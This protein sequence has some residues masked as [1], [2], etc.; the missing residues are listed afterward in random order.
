[1]L[2]RH[3]MKIKRV[4]YFCKWSQKREMEL[5][6]MKTY[7]KIKKKTV[8]GN[9]AYLALAETYMFDYIYPENTPTIINTF[10]VGCTVTILSMEELK[11]ALLEQ[12]QMVI[13][14]LVTLYATRKKEMLV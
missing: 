13:F 2:E 1:M 5:V 8:K 3:N 7:I 6:D 4:K 14:S 12:M 10:G 11:E 9:K